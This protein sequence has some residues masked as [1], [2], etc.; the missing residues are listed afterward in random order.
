MGMAPLDTGSGDSGY[1]PL[2]EINVTPL[3][4]VML[5]LLIIFM[6]AAPLMTVG[7]PVQ[8]PKTS[9]AK[10]AQPREPI[11]V[12][13]DAEGRV[14]LREEALAPDAVLPRLTELAANADP[15]TVV[16]V[17]GDR[18]LSYGQIMTIM[19]QVSTA[20][21]AKVSLIAHGASDGAGNGAADATTGE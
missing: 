1:R 6:V 4:D 7:V 19:G 2:A 3:V 16:Y 8:L 12:T 5:V 9:A 17:R 18:S 15:E 14:F 21:F 13:I 10:L 20:G 11:I